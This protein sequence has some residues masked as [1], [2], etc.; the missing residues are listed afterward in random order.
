MLLLGSACAW[1]DATPSGQGAPVADVVVRDQNNRQLHF[2]SDLLKGHIVAINFIFT[3]CS[4]VCP[5]TGANFAA[6]QKR[7]GKADAEVSLISVSIDPQNDTPAKLL[8]WRD[9]FGSRVKTMSDWELVTGCQADID[10]LLLS[11]GASTADPSTHTPFILI[12]DDI[13]GGARQRLDGLTDPAI[14]ARILH[15]R[16]RQ[17]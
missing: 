6:L 17:Q 16:V 2:Y 12:I 4:T 9:K 14:L 8:A 13:H 5:L 1:S 3:G 11:L 7:L 15:K 10:S